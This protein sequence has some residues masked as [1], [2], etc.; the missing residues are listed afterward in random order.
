M[1]WLVSAE[2]V[3]EVVDLVHIFRRRIV[4]EIYTVNIFVIRHIRSNK[5]IV[6]HEALFSKACVC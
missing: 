6:R 5:I 3:D 4:V 2:H 1:L